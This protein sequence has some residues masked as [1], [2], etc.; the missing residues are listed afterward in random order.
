VALAR[1]NNEGFGFGKTRAPTLERVVSLE[2]V[3]GEW[4]ELAEESR[5]VFAT[6]EWASIWWRHFGND[7]PLVVATF[8]S[9]EG[10]AIAILP[11]Y[12]WSARP[13]R[14]L[15]FLG[16]GTADELGPVCT[17]SR[18][19][20]AA[21]ALGR[22]LSDLKWD[23]FFGETLPSGEDWSRRLGAKVVRKDA[24]PVLCFRREGWEELLASRSHNF[25]QQ[26]RRR[27][28]NLARAH[29]LRFR[30]A[31]DANRLDHDLDLLFALH[32]ARW[33]SDS[34]FC[35]REA[36]HR[37][38]A[39]C[40]LERDWLRLWFLEVDGK[41]AAAWYG[42]RFGDVESYFQAGRDPVWERLSVGFVLLV[43]TIRE[44]LADGMREYRFLLGGED[45]KYRFAN[46]DRG[47][48][49]VALAR[50]LL[51]NAAL[52]AGLRLRQ[53]PSVQAGAARLAR[54]VLTR[55]R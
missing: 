11:L 10:T 39:A 33:G 26:V 22:A 53:S 18:R 52:T 8:R 45:Y 46:D 43:H 48:A 35:A 9:A 12:L 16:H 20:E 50:G 49:T 5:N 54:A 25:R 51:G 15:R 38:F 41:P 23:V 4:T 13:L 42:F 55:R 27:E 37:D 28:R 14:V 29:E 2:S 7:R 3:R 36:F 30:L 21:E 1:R 17:E 40:A 19:P 31:D 34:P 32:G 6:W 47:L 24:S 44:A